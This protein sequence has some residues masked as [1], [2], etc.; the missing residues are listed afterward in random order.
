MFIDD[1]GRSI[2]WEGLPRSLLVNMVTDYEVVKKYPLQMLNMV[3]NKQIED[4][5][6]LRPYSEISN[7]V[8]QSI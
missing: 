1:E 8:H 2:E 4:N 7:L 3:L 5:R 6:G